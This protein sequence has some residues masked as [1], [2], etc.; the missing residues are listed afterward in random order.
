MKIAHL[1]KCNHCKNLIIRYV[2]YKKGTRK[3]L[4]GNCAAELEPEH[5]EEILRADI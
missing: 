2:W 5:K 4:C 1:L 3:P